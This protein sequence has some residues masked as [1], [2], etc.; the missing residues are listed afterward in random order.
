MPFRFN[1]NNA[2]REKLQK[3]ADITIKNAEE[4]SQGTTLKGLKFFQI[5]MKSG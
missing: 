3:I 1:L 5:T 4:L 2:S